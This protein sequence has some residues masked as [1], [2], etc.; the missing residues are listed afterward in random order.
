MNEQQ[1]K[2]LDDARLLNRFVGR[3][4]LDST[5]SMSIQLFLEQRSQTSENTLRQSIQN[6]LQFL[7]QLKG[8]Y[9]Q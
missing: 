5:L 9:C 8:A 2:L 7:Q 3:L 1:Q 6:D 4:N